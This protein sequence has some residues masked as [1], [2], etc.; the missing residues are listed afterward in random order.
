MSVHPKTKHG[1]VKAGPPP[2]CALCTLHK[3]PQPRGRAEAGIQCA[4][5]NDAAPPRGSDFKKKSLITG[6]KWVPSDVIKVNVNLFFC[7]PSILRM[8]RSHPISSNLKVYSPEC[9]IVRCQP[10]RMRCQGTLPP[11]TH[12]QCFVPI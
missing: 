3:G 4:T 10:L 6:L 12:T 11:H 1:A 7:K 2:C 8:A 9:A 5:W